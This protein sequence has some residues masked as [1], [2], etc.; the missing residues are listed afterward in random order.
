[1]LRVTIYDFTIMVTTFITN[2][3]TK[4]SPDGNKLLPNGNKLL[5][6]VICGTKLLPD[7]FSVQTNLQCQ[8]FIY[9]FKSQIKL[10]KD[11]G[12]SLPELQFDMKASLDL[13]ISLR[14][15][16]SGIK[17]ELSKNIY[18]SGNDVARFWL[19]W[20]LKSNNETNQTYGKINKSSTDQAFG[21]YSLILHSFQLIYSLYHVYN[22]Y[23][24]YSLYHVYNIC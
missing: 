3:V 6:V 12:T 19:N 8:K 5:L 7:F 15:Y 16:P 21:H 4:F 22:I 17:K 14:N 18:K 24:I 9:V 10:F 13:Y 2:W 1:L 20:R 23:S 11:N